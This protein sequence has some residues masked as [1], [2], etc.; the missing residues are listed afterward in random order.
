MYIN[1]VEKL[2]KSENHRAQSIEDL[3]IE[4]MWTQETW[5]RKNYM[6]NMDEKK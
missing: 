1:I 4:K 6:K 5:T 2:S 3:W